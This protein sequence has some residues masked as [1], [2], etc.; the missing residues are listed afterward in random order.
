MIFGKVFAWSF[1]LAEILNFPG[2]SEVVF[3][4]KFHT[5]KK[6]RMKIW[7]T[8]RL[9]RETMCFE[10]IKRRTISRSD[11][12]RD[13]NS[14]MWPDNVR[15]ILCYFLAALKTLKISELCLWKK[16]RVYYYYYYHILMFLQVWRDS[17]CPKAE[18]LPDE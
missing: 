16:A 12:N 4:T 5:W 3:F 17:K 2:V 6:Q 18:I 7:T 1:N 10:D 8:G 13:N 15:T 9:L 11:H 14:S